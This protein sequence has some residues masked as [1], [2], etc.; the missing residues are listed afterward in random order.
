MPPFGISLWNDKENILLDLAF[1]PDKIGPRSAQ[2]PI[3]NGFVPQSSSTDRQL[4]LFVRTEEN[5]PLVYPSIDENT[6][7][8]NRPLGGPTFL[9]PDLEAVGRSL[10]E[11]HD[12]ALDFDRMNEASC[13]SQSE[14]GSF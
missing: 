13:A 11:K 14:A 12:R 4:T 5:S 7:E 6:I 2:Q 3:P 1:L 10:E 8:E 9:L